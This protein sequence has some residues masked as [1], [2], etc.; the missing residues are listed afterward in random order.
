MS[1]KGS[2]KLAAILQK[3]IKNLNNQS[4][5]V[6]VELA[7]I[8]SG[9]GLKVDSLPNFTIKR[10]EYFICKGV[11]ESTLQAGDRVLINWTYDGEIVVVDKL[12]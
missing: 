7:T 3:R 11:Y 2:S 8:T 4:Q 1:S 9:L 12:I 5:S 10:S 6:A